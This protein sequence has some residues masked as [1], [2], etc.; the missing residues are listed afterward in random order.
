M[1]KVIKCPGDLCI[2]YAGYVSEWMSTNKIYVV[3]V[4]LALVMIHLCYFIWQ[5]KR[6]RFACENAIL[7]F[8]LKSITHIGNTNRRKEESVL[9]SKNLLQLTG[10]TKKKVK[11]HETNDTCYGCTVQCW[12]W[13]YADRSLFIFE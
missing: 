12:F 7:P 9:E 5:N 8:F 2:P 1:G 3:C 11:R 4:V 6:T 13:D 10:G